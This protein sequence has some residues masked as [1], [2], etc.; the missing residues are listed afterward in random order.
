MIK[1]YIL[2]ICDPTNK[3]KIANSLKNIENVV[4]V[5]IIN[6]A[7][8]LILEVMVKKIDDLKEKFQKDIKNIDGSISTLTLLTSEDL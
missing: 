4:N 3:Y 6:G 8:D 1:A 5:D 7:Y 2:I